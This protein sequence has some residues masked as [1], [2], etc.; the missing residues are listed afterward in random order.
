MATLASIK[1]PGVYIQEMPSGSRPIEGVGTAVAAFIG[2]T[3][4]GPFNELIRVTNW[5]QYVRT[6]GGW[7]EG[8][9]L[10]HAVYQYFNNGGGTCYVSRIGQRGTGEAQYAS[11]EL[12]SSVKA[13]LGVY[14]IVA[15][16]AGVS[17]ENITVRVEPD[18]DQPAADGEEP[19]P[20][21]EQ[22]FTI[23]VR[24]DALEERYNG[25]TP[26]KGAGRN[27]PVT[28]LQSSALVQAIELGSAPVAE[29][30]PTSGEVVL[31]GGASLP[32]TLAPDDYLGDE[33]ARTGIAGL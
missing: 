33:P 17:G 1:S 19:R 30:I 23:V 8:G 12:T 9:Y 2:I 7:V 22:T 18:P 13:G 11:A 16:E 20:E 32:A 29:R 31:S 10:P 26:R 3:A 15:R 28:A 5:A 21:G 27:D 14:R 25:V 24:Q 6:F 4:D